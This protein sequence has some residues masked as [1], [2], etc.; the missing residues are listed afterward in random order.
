LAADRRRGHTIS[1][2][3]NTGLRISSSSGNKVLGN[4]IGTGPGGFN[5]L[6]NGNQGIRLDNAHDNQIGNTHPGEPNIIAANTT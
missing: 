2:N 6:G 3:G 4:F 1:A 5:A